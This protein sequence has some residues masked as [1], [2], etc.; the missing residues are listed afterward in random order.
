MVNRPQLNLRCSESSG[1]E[2]AGQQ[3]ELVRKVIGLI[4][5]KRVLPQDPLELP[6]R[7]ELTEAPQRHNGLGSG[8]QIAFA[9]ATAL[10]HCCKT[11]TPAAGPMAELVGRGKRSAIGSYGFFSGGCIADSGIAGDAT[12]SPIETRIDFP[13][14]WPIVLIRPEQKAG[15]HGQHEQSAFNRLRSSESKNRQSL[16]QLATQ[17]I[18]PGI[19]SGDYRR[20][21]NALHDFNRISG[22]YFS[23]FQSGAYNS[24]RC[25]EIVQFVREHGCPAVGQSSWGPTLFAVASSNELADDLVRKLREGCDAIGDEKETE[26]II[27]SANNVGMQIADHLVESQ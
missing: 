6:I 24:P 10:M 14:G 8:T 21:A 26:I 19:E 1:F 20:F 5:E 22:E 16:K 7:I 2:L 4:R 25:A 11:P 13:T 23:E 15:L 27:T 3:Q 18:V 12:F 9:V 17:E